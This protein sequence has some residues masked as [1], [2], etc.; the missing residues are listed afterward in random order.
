VLGLPLGDGKPYYT[1]ERTLGVVEPAASTDEEFVL[2]TPS[3][4]NSPTKT[5]PNS[6]SSPSGQGFAEPT[7]HIEKYWE[8]PP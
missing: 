1:A 6:S 8:P 4:P 2:Y 3:K 7:T 5:G